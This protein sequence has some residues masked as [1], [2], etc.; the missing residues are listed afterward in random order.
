MYE[1]YVVT[2]TFMRVFNRGENADFDLLVCEA[3]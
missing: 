2:H 1:K 3:T